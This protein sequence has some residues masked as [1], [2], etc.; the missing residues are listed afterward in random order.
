ML[1]EHSEEIVDDVLDV[2][3]KHTG[4]GFR[5]K[6]EVS[7]SESFLGV[8]ERWLDDPTWKCANGHISKRYLKSEALGQN[9]CLECRTPVRL[10]DPNEQE[11]RPE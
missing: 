6:E 9:V 8:P 1:P 3:E 5:L 2:V 11:R 7:A 10:C 4:D